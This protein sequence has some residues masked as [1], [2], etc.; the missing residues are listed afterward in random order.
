MSARRSELTRQAAQA[1]RRE[2]LPRHVDRRHR[3]GARRPEG[4]ALLAH[5]RRRRTCST[6]RCWEG[7]AAFHAALDAIPEDAPPI[8]KIRLALRGA[9]ARRRRAARRRH[10]LRP[11][12]ALPRGRAARRVRRRA[13]PLRG[14]DPRRSSARARELGELRIRPRRRPRPRCSLL[15]A[16]NWAYTWLQPGRDTDELAD[17]F[18]A[19]LV[20]GMRGYSTSL[21]CRLAADRQPVREPGDGGARARA[22]ARART[23]SRRCSPSGAGHATELARDAQGDAVFV[24][25]GDGVVNEVLNGLPPA[26]RSGSSPAAT[27]TSSPARSACRRDPAR[28]PVRERRISLGRVNGRRFAFGAGIGVDSETVRELETLE[29]RAPTAGGAATSSYARVAARRLLA[30]RY[31]PPGARDRRS[32]PGGARSSSRTT[33][34]T[35]AGPRP[36]PLLARRRASSS[37]ST[38]SRRARPGARRRRAT[39][40][41]SLRGTGQRACARRPATRT[42]ST[43][44]WSLRRAAAAPGR[45]RGPRRRHRGGLRGR[46]RRGRG[47]RREIDIARRGAR[48]SRPSEGFAA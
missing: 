26:S 24:F 10:R 44:S 15:S 27:R 18:L 31:E 46:A 25:G 40:P 7:A 5:R 23:R 48:C 6:R 42:T 13:A 17:R 28:R 38:W 41:T 35:Y 39:S 19:L 29:A 9:P 11:G 37:G 16:A 21:A 47:P 3:R 12:V 34:F 43:A 36:V 32:R 4:L 2:G 8:E 45:R 22:R 20:D 33:P 30:R 1:L 14:A